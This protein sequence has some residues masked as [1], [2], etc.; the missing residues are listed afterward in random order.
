LRPDPPPTEGKRRL[1]GNK[2]ESCQTARKKGLD[3]SASKKKEDRRGVEKE[4][5]GPTRKKK[6]KKRGVGPEPSQ[7][8]KGLFLKEDAVLAEGKWG[9]KRVDCI[10]WTQ[11][12]SVFKIRWGGPAPPAGKKNWTRKKGA[13]SPEVFSYA[14][15]ETYGGPDR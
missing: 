15:R 11:K 6:R 4:G 1:V 9:G 12:N 13:S 5:G 7:K 3:D 10:S 14:E 8:E 2:E